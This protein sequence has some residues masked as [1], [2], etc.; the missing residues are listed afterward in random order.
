MIESFFR[1]LD[2]SE[3]KYLLISGQASVL[4]GAATFSEDIDLWLEP[5]QANLERFRSVL[6]G[7]EARFYKLTPPFELEIMRR[8][9]GFHFILPE[10]SNEP[11]F[12]DVMGCPPRTGPF[13][14]VRD[15]SKSLE[16][17][18]GAIPTIGIW[19]LVELKK[20]QR[21]EDYPVIGRLVLAAA[22]QGLTRVEEVG[23]A[24]TNIFTLPELRRFFEELPGVLDLWPEGQHVELR[25]FGLHAVRDED[26]AGTVERAVQELFQQRI[27]VCQHADR[28]YWRPIIAELRAF[29][30]DNRLMQ[31]GE[32]V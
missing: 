2:A 13:S 17:E 24:L 3:V 29:R 8:G 27:S 9:H 1:D 30:R 23:W 32:L 26:A 21:I 28:I 5:S 11:V 7:H 19:D 6:S 10:G 16:T 22:L 14:A 31:E 20:T 12:L 25:E 18:W 4:Y 15:R